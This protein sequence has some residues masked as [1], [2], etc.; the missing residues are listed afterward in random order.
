MKKGGLFRLCLLTFIIGFLFGCSGDGGSVGDNSGG[1]SGNGT[2][3]ATGHVTDPLGDS[4]ISANTPVSPDIVDV[5][6]TV[7][8][9]NVT[10]QI[11][12]KSGSFDKAKNIVTLAVDADQKTTGKN[13]D[14]LGIDYYIYMGS[15]LYGSNAVVMRLTGATERIQDASVPVTFG[16]DG[17]DVTIPLS[18]LSHLNNV[19]VFNYRLYVSVMAPDA[20]AENIA[21]VA[22]GRV[23]MAPDINL[24]PASTDKDSINDTLNAV[25]GHISDP[26]GDPFSSVYATVSPDIVDIKTIVSG[27]N[28]TFQIRFKGGTF[29]KSRDLVT[30]YID[31][32]RN[33]GTGSGQSGLGIDYYVFMGS[34][35]YG[36]NASIERLTGT[37][38]TN[39][40]MGSAPITFLADGM[41]V[42]FPLS[43]LGNVTSFDYRVNVSILISGNSFTGNIDT[44]PD[45]NLSPASTDKDSIHNTIS[46]I[47]TT[48]S[49]AQ[50]RQ[51]VID[52]NI[53]APNQNPGHIARWNTPI[54]V[55][56]NN[57]ARVEQ[58][59][60]R[61]EKLSGGL[62]TFKRVTGTP[63]NGVVYVE[64]TSPDHN[65]APGCGNVA[66]FPGGSGVGF[67]FDSSGAMYGLYY[68]NLGSPGCNDAQIGDYESAIAEHE[69]GH[70]LGIWGHFDGYTGGEGLMNANFFNV[71][72]NIY[73]NPI[74]TTAGA[75]NISVVSVGQFGFYY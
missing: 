28:V 14:G 11:R 40:K 5:K 8:A 68:I 56:T 55:N 13:Q 45:S 39:V 27:E 32:D 41:D 35:V 46:P 75:L 22:P 50:I 72:Y 74:G 17:M 37:V 47:P 6:T 61:Y 48:W 30:V 52:V 16:P 58:A 70:A 26:A 2:S 63:T 51:Q 12:F 20:T 73:N 9:A 34:D 1:G 54:E 25:N 23:D 36:S 42:A 62:I 67:K 69:M 64:G 49:A 60:T 31:A 33:T 29:D 4:S 65:G 24:P 21:D 3:T 38:G 66:D 15:T 59:L 10:F 18:A 7:D 43:Y 71:S 19:T 44:A 53:N 57:I